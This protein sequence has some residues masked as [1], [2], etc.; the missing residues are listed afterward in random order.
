MNIAIVFSFFIR[1][2]NTTLLYCT[3][4]LH[5]D[6]ILHLRIHLYYTLWIEWF[7]TTQ[8]SVQ[9]CK[10]KSIRWSCRYFVVLRA[11]PSFVDFWSFRTATSCG[12]LGFFKTFIPKNFYSLMILALK[13]L[14]N[15]QSLFS[16][17]DLRSLALLPK[18]HGGRNLYLN[19]VK[20]CGNES[21]SFINLFYK[22]PLCVAF[23]KDLETFLFHK[24]DSLIRLDLSL[25][26]SALWWLKMVH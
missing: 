18:T 15:K 25:K 14:L 5:C 4:Q 2:N 3:S 16:F 8:C 1:V 22:C 21:E 11:Q 6:R 19:F 7:N 12:K 20:F 17:R 10:E 23:W 9:F 24:I 13:C 26:I